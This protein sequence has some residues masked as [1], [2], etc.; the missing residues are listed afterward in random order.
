MADSSDLRSGLDDAIRICGSKAELARRLGITRGA[1]HQWD[2]CPLER[3][4]DIERVTGVSRL[5]L[6]P[7]FFAKSGEAA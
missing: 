6:R 7:D 5:R 3:A 2:V 1:V 4:I